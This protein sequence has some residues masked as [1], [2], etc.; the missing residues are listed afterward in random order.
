M[1]NAISK[2]FNVDQ[3]TT[4]SHEIVQRAAETVRFQDLSGLRFQGPVTYRDLME[5]LLT[6]Q[7]DLLYAVSKTGKLEH[8]IKMFKIL[9]AYVGAQR[10]ISASNANKI[11]TCCINL[12]FAANYIIENASTNAQ[13]DELKLIYNK[14]LDIALRYHESEA[15]IR[16]LVNDI[17]AIR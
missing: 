9:D 11:V 2:L 15:N 14:I 13:K 12:R 10:K 3:F 8:C 6:S 17:S 5:A 7:S 1:I 4:D 16:I